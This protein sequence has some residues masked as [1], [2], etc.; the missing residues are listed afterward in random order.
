M[1]NH[2]RQGNN[3]NNN[4]EE[5]HLPEWET[6][7]RHRGEKPAHTDHKPSVIERGFIVLDRVIPRHKTYFGFSRK[8]I[9]IALLVIFLVL[10]ALIL[11]LAIGLSKK[12]RYA[13][14]Q[15]RFPMTCSLNIH[16]ATIRISLWDRK[17]TQE[18][19]LITV[20][21]LV[22]VASLLPTPTTLYPSAT[23]PLTPSPKAPTRMQIHFAGI[24]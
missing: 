13:L 9:C 14:P 10:L 12:S 7:A 5:F 1:Q 24:S 15:H 2:E 4:I 3:N 8:I 16:P 21:D 11:G 22:L 6:T 17:P 19:S 20:L 23:L 18:I